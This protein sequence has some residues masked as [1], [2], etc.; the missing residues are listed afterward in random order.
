MEG[1]T[2]QRIVELSEG[3]L[4]V[5][6]NLKPATVK[7]IA[8][9]CSKHTHTHSDQNGTYLLTLFPYCSSMGRL[10]SA[11]KLLYISMPRSHFCNTWPDFSSLSI[12]PD[13]HTL[14]KVSDT[15]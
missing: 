8:P 13:P 6:L 15:Y 11:F 10:N 5:Q 7:I 14:G 12:L 9:G 3:N 4:S 1:L 2:L